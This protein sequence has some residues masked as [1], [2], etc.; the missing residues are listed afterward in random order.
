M[1]DISIDILHVGYVK[2]VKLIINKQDR[3][4][5]DNQESTQSQLK[6]QM[7]LSLWFEKYRAN[8]RQS[9]KTEYGNYVHVIRNNGKVVWLATYK[10]L[11][12]TEI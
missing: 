6:N 11:K 4:L 12:Q 9:W 7:T 2:D 5:N 1:P 8:T 3:R 10:I